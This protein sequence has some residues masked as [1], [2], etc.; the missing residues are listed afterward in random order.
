MPSPTNPLRLSS[1]PTLPLLYRL[2][3]L[4]PSPSTYTPHAALNAR[5]S[6]LR[7]DI[8][9]LALAAIV[10]A[11]NSSLLGGGGVDG[12]IH[13]RAGPDLLGEC[14]TLGGCP[15]GRAKI[16]GAYELPCDRVIHAVGPVYWVAKEAEGGV[17]RKQLRGCYVSALDLAQEHGCKSIAFSCI[18][19]GVYGYP[20]GEAAEVACEAVREWL[21]EREEEGWGGIERVVCCCFEAKDER[22]YERALP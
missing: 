3:K 22:A 10:N 11:A 15:T 7:T 6:L 14:R 1:I 9:T 19:T 4:A 8:T 2:S 5:I 20:S 16:T 17:E 12:A 18:S 13:A 21:L